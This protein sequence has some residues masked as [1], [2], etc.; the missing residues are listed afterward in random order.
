[1]VWAKDNKTLFYI[2]EDPKTKRANRIF[3]HRIG[4]PKEADV[5][6]YEE[7]RPGYFP[8]I[9]LSDSRDYILLMSSSFVDSKVWVLPSDQPEAAF[10]PFGNKLPKAMYQLD[11]TAGNEWTLLTDFKAPNYRVVRLTS[12]QQPTE[13]WKNI[14][15]V[16]DSSFLQD[17]RMLKDYQITHILEK[18][19]PVMRVLNRSNDS[20]FVLPFPDG[21]FSVS[22]LGASDYQDSVI[23]Y[24]STSMVVLS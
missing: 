19:T 12:L 10:Q 23:R 21:P 17:F 13:D 1:M 3:R 16:H 6:V 22:L 5:L 2:F 9:G 24:S 20:S 11:H 14:V 7:K 15:T 18:G 8:S 4:T